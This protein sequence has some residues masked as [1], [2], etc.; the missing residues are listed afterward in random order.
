MKKSNKLY[1][2]S[3]IELT[4]FIAHNYDFLM[5]TLSFGKYRRF[6]HHPIDDIGIEPSNP[7]I[8]LGCETG[9]NAG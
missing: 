8:D 7:I 5:N 4:A 1:P 6:I 3:G 9:R 2:E